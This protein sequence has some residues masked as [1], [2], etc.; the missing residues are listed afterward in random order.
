MVVSIVIGI[1][2]VIG[3][4]V[5]IGRLYSE[6]EAMRIKI[7]SLSTKPKEPPTETPKSIVPKPVE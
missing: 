2:T 6:L 1:L 7:A 3:M 4:M 5:V